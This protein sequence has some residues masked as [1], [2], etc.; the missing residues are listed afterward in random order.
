MISSSDIATEGDARRGGMG[1]GN[2]D[3]EDVGEGVVTRSGVKALSAF[4]KI[5][6]CMGSSPDNTSGGMG[7]VNEMA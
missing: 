4:K 2:D 1:R 7:P 5:C 6:R 3:D